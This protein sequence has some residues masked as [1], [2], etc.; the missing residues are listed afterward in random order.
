MPQGGGAFIK[1]LGSDISFSLTARQVP[2][3]S[4]FSTPFLHSR[5]QLQAQ[6]QGSENLSLAF[7]FF[8]FLFSFLRADLCLY[9]GM[10]IYVGVCI[11]PTGI[12]LPHCP[13]LRYRCSLPHLPL[14]QVLGSELRFNA[15][16]AAVVLTKSHTQPLSAKFMAKQTR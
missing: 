5:W 2:R 13:A 10:C 12:C 4:L 3:G 8:S 14:Q 9:R 6:G 7:G 15:C 1:F 16:A 11:Y